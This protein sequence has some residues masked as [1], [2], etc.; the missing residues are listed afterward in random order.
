[1]IMPKKSS[2]KSEYTFIREIGFISIFL[3]FFCLQADAVQDTLSSKEKLPVH[4]RLLLKKDEVTGLKTAIEQS[5]DLKTIHDAVI[6][7]SRSFIH[8]PKLTY[9]KEGM[10]LLAVSREALHRIYYMSYAYRLT[11]DKK[12]A[13]AVEQDLLEI[14][15]FQDWNPSHFL[16][17]AEMTMAAAIGYDWLYDELSSSS[18]KI[19]KNAIV[20]KGLKPSLI[21][22]PNS[23]LLRTNNWNQVCNAGMTFGAIAVFEDE[24]N[25]ARTIIN[26][27]IESIKLPMI[28]YGSDGAYQEGFSYWDYGTSFNTMYLSA[29]EKA[30]GTDFGLS[31]SFPGYMNT[32]AYYLHMVGSSGEA[33]NYSDG[34]SLAEQLNPSVYWFAV[35]R[36]DPSLLWNQGQLL[37]RAGKETFSHRLLPSLLIWA[38]DLNTKG[39]TPPK[40]SFWVGGGVNPVC[41]MRSSWNEPSAVFLG[42]KTGTPNAPHGHMDIGSF[43]MDADGVRWASDLGMQ[44]YYSLEKEGIRLFGKDR[45]RIFRYTNK[46]HNVIIF[47]DTLQKAAGKA[48]INSYS[49]K[50][51][52][53]TAVSDVSDLSKTVQRH[54]RSA[55]MVNKAYVLIEDSIAA[56]DKPVDIRWNMLTEAAPEVLN[57]STFLLKK[58]G[59]ELYMKVR[60]SRPFTL[61]TWSSVPPER[62]D[63]PNPGTIF[64]GFTSS[65]EAGMKADYKV[66]LV[67]KNA[68]QLF[69]EHGKAG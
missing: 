68:V 50:P 66:Y 38:K 14:C 29:L 3:F 46:S 60:S 37:G 53:M 18:R 27:S 24:E 25:L 54:I 33:F 52:K 49:N 22:M 16:D 21:K 17:A 59:R 23:W 34:S 5:S 28:E 40:E 64:V 13:E 42:F 4:P 61:K 39:I 65:L 15:A 19:I 58:N 35:K 7:I 62:F 43:V 41:L 32:A 36:N 11:N 31:E 51:D 47:N 8:S 6:R 57:D 2:C 44:N 30:F 55:S 1:M 67:P 56:S 45:W 9:N 12:Y 48:V 63:A 26:R 20:E 10:R 69:E